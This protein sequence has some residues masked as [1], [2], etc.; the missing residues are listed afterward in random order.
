M[1]SDPTSPSLFS[2]PK[3]FVDDQCTASDASDAD[4]VQQGEAIASL[5]PDEQNLHT[6]VEDARKSFEQRPKMGTSRDQASCEM[7]ISNLSKRVANNTEFEDAVTCLRQNFGKLHGTDVGQLLTV[8][9]KVRDHYTAIADRTSLD[10]EAHGTI[11]DI[12]TA[13]GEMTT[14]HDARNEMQDIHWQ[15]RTDAQQRELVGLNEQYRLLQVHLANTRNKGITAFL[16]Y[17]NYGKKKKEAIDNAK[18]SRFGSVPQQIVTANEEES[19]K[20]GTALDQVE[21]VTK[22]VDKA[23]DAVIVG[24]ENEG[25]ALKETEA[26]LTKQEKHL[27]D[28]LAKVEAAQVKNREEQAKNK[29]ELE[30]AQAKRETDHTYLVD[31]HSRLTTRRDLCEKRKTVGEAMEKWMTLVSDEGILIADE[32]HAA[33][34]SRI[35]SQVKAFHRNLDDLLDLTCQIRFRTVNRGNAAAEECKVENRKLKDAV[36]NLAACEEKRKLVD[37][38]KQEYE[39][40]ATLIKD[41]DTCYAEAQVLWDSRQDLADELLLGL[42]LAKSQKDRTADLALEHD[43]D[44]SQIPVLE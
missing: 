39:D 4:Y 15:L 19:K 34:T 13:E 35:A 32:R 24:F 3:V 2:E 33:V 7:I 16:E 5:L 17:N 43:D 6:L 44:D 23:N 9:E 12:I 38:L 41:M 11:Q 27:R 1:A 31:V 10:D 30:N 25:K 37:K 22:S 29:V 14:A 8:L 20:M 21:K 18:Q 40:A 42:A 36:K 26:D 28:M